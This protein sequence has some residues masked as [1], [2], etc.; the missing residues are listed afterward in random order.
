VSFT[1]P[2]ASCPTQ[3]RLNFEPQIGFAWDPFG[4]GKTVKR[5][6][7]PLADLYAVR[8]F[9]CTGTTSMTVDAIEW[10]LQNNMQVI[11]MSLGSDFGIRIVPMPK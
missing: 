1:T 9:G 2:F 11:N 7:A 4:T 5:G 10:A 8:I 3:P 6:I